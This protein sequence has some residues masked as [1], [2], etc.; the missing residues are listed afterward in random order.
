MS[1]ATKPNRKRTSLRRR[2]GMSIL[3]LIGG[4]IVFIGFTSFA[5]DFGR[6]QVAKTELRRAAD[7]A[8]RA[9][10]ADLGT[11]SVA[12]QDAYDIALSNT[13]LGDPVTLDKPSDIEMGT[14]DPT[15]R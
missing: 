13:C 10:A 12:Q 2:A 8:A 6:V 3:Y 9:G 15:N 7:A 14:W 1:M 11:P 5:V 4:M